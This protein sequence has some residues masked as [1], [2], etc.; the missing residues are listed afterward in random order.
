M[1]SFAVANLPQHHLYSDL[2]TVGVTQQRIAEVLG[3]LPLVG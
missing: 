1:M 3:T 2:I